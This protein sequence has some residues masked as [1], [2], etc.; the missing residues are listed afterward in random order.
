MDKAATLIFINIYFASRSEFCLILREEKVH[1]WKAMIFL[2][3]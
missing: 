2:N 1:F 3:L